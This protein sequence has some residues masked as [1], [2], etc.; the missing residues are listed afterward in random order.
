MPALINSNEGE[1]EATLYFKD[2]TSPQLRGGMVFVVVKGESFFI[3]VGLE[4]VVGIG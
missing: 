2:K 1:N 4:G 3:D